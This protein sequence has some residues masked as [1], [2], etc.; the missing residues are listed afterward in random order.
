M[1]RRGGDLPSPKSPLLLPR[2]IGVRWWRQKGPVASPGAMGEKMM[3]NVEGDQVATGRSETRSK[4]EVLAAAALTVALAT[5]NRVFYKLALIPLKN[6]PFFLAQLATFG[7]VVVYFSILYFRYHAGIVTDKMLSLPKGPY[8][9]IGLLETISAVSGMAAT[10]VLSGAS[11]PILSQTFLVWQLILSYLVLGRRYRFN[12]V[13]GCLLVSVGVIITVMSGTGSSV[14]LRGTEIFWTLLMINS[15]LFQAADTVLKEIIFENAT[16]KLKGGSVD[17]FVVNSYGSAFQALFTCLLLP[18]LT[19]L[20][21]IPLAQL[22]AYIKDGTACFLNIGSLSHGCEGAPLLPVLF[23]LVNMAFNISLLN[24]VKISSGVASCLASTF[25]VPLSIYVF[26][27]PLPYAGV[28]SPLPAGFLAGAAV[29]VAGLLLYSFT[30]PP[31]GD[32]SAAAP[33]LPT[34]LLRSRGGVLAEL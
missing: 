16:K 9:A 12:Q 32:Q 27:L 11:I 33:L 25:S 3:G 29:L 26:T 10:A 8:V 24:L 17:I 1:R 15:F 30:P 34:P 22:P 5:G 20:W 21:G 13:V 19:K 4:K 18:L 7:Y 2:P 14:S 6:Y 23:V 28:P 31:P